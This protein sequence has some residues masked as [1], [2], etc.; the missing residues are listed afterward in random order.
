MSDE[1]SYE[2]G[3][4]NVEDQ[5]AESDQSAQEAAN[6]DKKEE[7]EVEEH[8]NAD[9][10]SYEQP[11]LA[12]AAQVSAQAADDPDDGARLAKQSDET[13]TSPAAEPEPDAG[14]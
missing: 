1:G 6:G 11:A 7:D 4:T 10:G 14:T 9:P 13:H 3:T 5:A 12:Q 8:P 2:Q